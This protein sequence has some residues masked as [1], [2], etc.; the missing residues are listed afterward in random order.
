MRG[1]FLSSPPPRRRLRSPCEIEMVIR[2]MDELRRPFLSLPLFH[3]GHD[4]GER[5]RP[6]GYRA[7]AA[8]TFFSP[9]SPPPPSR[10]LR[11]T[12]FRNDACSPADNERVSDALRPL[13]LAP[14]FPP[15]P[16]WPFRNIGRTPQIRKNPAEGQF[17]RKEKAF[18]LPP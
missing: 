12:A 4:N 11:P 16:P 6:P 18:P 13:R 17:L 5:S 8:D 7:A 10:A 9:P 3:A 14:F 1:S 2:G 15:P